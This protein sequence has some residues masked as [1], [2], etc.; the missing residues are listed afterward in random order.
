V[1]TLWVAAVAE[2]E[3]YTW[4]EGLSFGRAIAGRFA[5][6]KGRSIGVFEAPEE[7]PERAER[8]ARE[9]AGTHPVEVFGTR[10]LARTD[11]ATGATLAA[12]GAGAVA[13]ASV[14]SYL[15][16]AFGD[17]LER[18]K[19]ALR[20]L[21]AAAGRDKLRRRSFAYDLY[22]QIRPG[23]PGGKAGWG[24]KGLLDLLHVD[25][26]AETLRAQAEQNDE[27]PGR[28]AAGAAAENAAG[29]GKA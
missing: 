23:V 6:A 15:A 12:D 4:E 8:R 17:K 16:R 24:K 20:G 13:P 27:E 25:L 14:A 29:G 9:R 28:G 10:V 1:L 26:L 11:A 22:T 5:Q 7:T 19:G 18:A 21:A 2:C 3:G